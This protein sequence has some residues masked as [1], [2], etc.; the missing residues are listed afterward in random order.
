M[1]AAQEALVA[2]IRQFLERIEKPGE[3]APGTQLY[4]EGIGLDSIE[5]AELSAILEDEFGSD[6]YTADEMPQTLGDIF[7]FYG[8]TVDA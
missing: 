1:A 5:T 7:R 2:T 3:L 6:P 4:A 8:L